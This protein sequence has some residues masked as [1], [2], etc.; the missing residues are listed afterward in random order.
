MKNSSLGGGAP[1]WGGG[2]YWEN[3]INSDVPVIVFRPPPPQVALPP[4]GGNSHLQ[5]FSSISLK[6]L[7]AK[8][9]KIRCKSL[10]VRA[11][12]YSAGP[13]IVSRVV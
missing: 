6:N 2:G 9:T 4:T 12:S 5:G 7:A 8:L 13:K 10:L 1:G 11:L 3:A